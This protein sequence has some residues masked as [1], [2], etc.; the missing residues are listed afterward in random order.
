MSDP[1][2]RDVVAAIHELARRPHRFFATRPDRIL[3]RSRQVL[4]AVA[5]SPAAAPGSSYRRAAAARAH[6]RDDPAVASRPTYARAMVRRFERDGRSFEIDA[7]IAWV[8]H[9][10]SPPPG[11]TARWSWQRSDLPGWGETKSTELA[12]ERARAGWTEVQV[13]AL[14]GT[15]SSTG[16]SSK[17]RIGAETT[18]AIETLAA[19]NDP[20]APLASELTELC[21]GATAGDA[22]ISSDG[23]DPLELVLG[24]ATA[25][26]A[27][28]AELAFAKGWLRPST[29]AAMREQW[30]EPAR[31]KSDPA[32]AE[33]LDGLAVTAGRTQCV[34]LVLEQG[35][36]VY[37]RMS[38]AAIPAAPDQLCVLTP[39]LKPEAPPMEFGDL[40][41]VPPVEPNALTQEVRQLER[42]LAGAHVG[43]VL[44]EPE[45]AAGVAVVFDTS[46]LRVFTRA[47]LISG[48]A[49]AYRFAG[50]R[51]PSPA[52][53][54]LSAAMLGKLRNV[55][56][57]VIGTFSV[58]RLLFLGNAPSGRIVGVQ[59]FASW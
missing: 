41:H 48:S 38:M 7:G 17:W 36:H 10:E 52:L 31:A 34:E 19:A 15:G 3:S 40:L 16:K 18:A 12:E 1:L 44:L 54:K 22:G 55:R 20:L 30:M 11:R 28:L 50:F 5:D 24:P 47:M 13:P 21:R 6:R 46:Q 56:L 35:G 8:A 45:A 39:V 58:R 42:A 14:D 27:D 59:T 9:R 26:E 4:E 23:G 2:A 43:V 53:E 37:E 25:V 57:Y 51:E 29:L 49:I 33:A 32:L